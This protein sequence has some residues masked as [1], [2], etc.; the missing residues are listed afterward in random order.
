[1][2]WLLEPVGLP[3]VQGVKNGIFQQDN[4]RPHV[5]R[6]TLWFLDENNVNV[7]PWLARFP[8]LSPIENLLDMIGRR[9]LK[10]TNPA[11]TRNE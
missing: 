4:A 11:T 1:M 5:S 6:S 3:F 10:N 7:M 2:V 9:L 8:D